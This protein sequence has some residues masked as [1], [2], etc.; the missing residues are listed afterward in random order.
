MLYRSVSAVLL[1]A[2]CQE[3]AVSNHTLHLPHSFGLQ[4]VIDKHSSYESKI[5]FWFIKQ[6][7]IIRQEKKHKTTGAQRIA[8][9]L[10]WR[11]LNNLANNFQKT[12]SSGHVGTMSSLARGRRY[13]LHVSLFPAT[14]PTPPCDLKAPLISCCKLDILPPPLSVPDE[15]SNKRPRGGGGKGKEFGR[16]W[17]KILALAFPKEC[18]LSLVNVATAVQSSRN[19]ELMYVSRLNEK[20]AMSRP[21]DCFTGVNLLP[22]LKSGGRLAFAISFFCHFWMTYYHCEAWLLGGDNKL[23]Y[24]RMTKIK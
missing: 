13:F 17:E 4:P 18:Y 16:I 19:S 24:L 23:L 15:K 10:S 20:P 2:F 14:N 6:W 22:Q 3:S 21:L 8:W 11:V 12:T 1:Q 5:N 7:A 9:G